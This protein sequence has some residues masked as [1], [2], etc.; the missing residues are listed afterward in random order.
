MELNT[1]GGTT[2]TDLGTTQMMSVPYALFA[3]VAGSSNQTNSNYMPSA[4]SVLTLVGVAKLPE[5]NYTVP[6]N[7]TWKIVSIT[8]PEEVNYSDYKIYLNGCWQA[9][10]STAYCQYQ[11]N[12]YSLKIGNYQYTENPTTSLFTEV[13]TG[14][15]SQCPAF[16]TRGFPGYSGGNFNNLKLPLWAS[17]SENISVGRLFLVFVEKYR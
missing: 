5:G 6:N 8:I 1:T 2:Y 7:E 11:N 12:L 16:I 13:I 3:G 4:D 10:Q 14:T 15:C 17:N 9:N